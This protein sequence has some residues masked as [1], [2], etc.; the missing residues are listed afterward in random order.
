MT[1]LFAG[2]FDPI[3]LGHVDIIRRACALTDKLVVAV[4]HNPAKKGA[5]SLEDRLSM[6]RLAVGDMP[7]VEIA[8]FDGLLVD[9]CRQKGI[10]A[11][12]RGIRNTIDY[13]YETGMALANRKLGGLE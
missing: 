6:I 5:F 2:S 1:M 12:V 9:F 11:S 13:E 4:M 7:G 8:A 3:T 10:T